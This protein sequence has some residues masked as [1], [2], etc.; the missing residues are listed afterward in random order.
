MDWWLALCEVV[1]VYSGL[2]KQAIDLSTLH[3]YCVT[4]FNIS[5]T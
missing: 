3:N 1:I 4:V 5:I 2:M